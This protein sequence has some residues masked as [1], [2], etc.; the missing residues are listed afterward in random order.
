MNQNS[1]KLYTT[2][3]AGTRVM[4]KDLTTNQILI[5][6]KF[7]SCGQFACLLSV[8]RCHIE[9]SHPNVSAILFS[10]K[11][12]SGTGA[13]I[14]LVENRLISIR[15]PPFLIYSSASLANVTISFIGNAMFASPLASNP[16]AC[17]HKLDSGS[18]SELRSLE[19]WGNFLD[20]IQHRTSQKLLLRPQPISL[21]DRLKICC[22]GSS[23]QQRKQQSGSSRG[24]NSIISYIEMERRILN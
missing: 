15:K 6:S 12:T 13:L 11:T 2:L 8:E 7:E 14:L 22:C 17:I 19:L 1:L 4:L 16:T 10:E 23:V 20:P 21:H 9:A 24:K 18:I 5:I 3:M